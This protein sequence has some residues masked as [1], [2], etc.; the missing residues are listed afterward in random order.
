MRRVIYAAPVSWDRK[1]YESDVF[2]EELQMRLKL[3]FGAYVGDTA[4][5]LYEDVIRRAFGIVTTFDPSK[6][7][8]DLL[9]SISANQ[10]ALQVD[11]NSGWAVFP[12]GEIIIL[13]MYGMIKN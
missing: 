12:T 2:I 7:G 4:G 3:T 1:K 11:I 9:V 5:T 13:Y 6:G 8:A 10:N